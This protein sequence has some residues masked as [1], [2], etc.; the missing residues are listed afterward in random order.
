MAHAVL[1]PSSAHRWMACAAAP[2]MESKMPEST[3]VYAAEGTKAHAIAA[4]L[5]DPANEM[6]SI[7]VMMMD[8]TDDDLKAIQDYVEFVDEETK[9]GIREIER[10]TDISKSTGEVGAKGTIDCAA[11][12]GNTLKIIDLK[13][14]MG[15]KVDAI[16][17]PQ[18]MLYALGAIDEFG[19]YDE[20]K[21][22]E[23]IIHQPRLNHV[24][25]WA[26]SLSDLEA[27]KEKALGCAKR[28]FEVMDKDL[29]DSSYFGPCEKACRFCRAKAFCP[30]LKNAVVNVLETQE[31]KPMSVRPVESFDN[32]TLAYA[33]THL[34]M[35]EGW[36]KSVRET[37]N[38]R[39]NRGEDIPGFK[40]VAGRK[41][42][43]KWTNE[44]TA[45]SI[46][47]SLV[48]EKAFTKKVI[49]P[50]QADKLRK[51]KAIDAESWPELADLIT[52]TDGAPCCVPATDPRPAL[53]PTTF[54]DFP[55]LED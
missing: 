48:G 31:A 19:L 8:L 52:Q 14:G 5:L 18:L 20:I 24:S 3:S 35:I 45:A 13:F 50:T 11:L 36:C 25:R 34:E 27:F 21:S 2:A 6:E 7:T 1:S 51:A 47:E 12:V 37:A 39:L 30:A 40:L 43:R 38:E 4:G 49:T 10:S 29:I 16:E 28:C 41:G 15:V 53:L 32:A 46:L 42:V 44:E 9:G 22:V 54:T 26:I 33:L 55:L 17:N 23:L